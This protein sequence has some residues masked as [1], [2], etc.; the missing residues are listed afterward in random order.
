MGKS[1]LIG[2]FHA[3]RSWYNSETYISEKTR[4]TLDDD[5]QDI[6]QSCLKESFE[7]L[8]QHRD[9]FEYFAQELLAKGEMEYDEIEAVFKK[10]NV[11]PKYRPPFLESI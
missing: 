7:I 2:D 6:L 4:Q 9:L 5:V 3:M 8:N 11:Q 10:F 1:G